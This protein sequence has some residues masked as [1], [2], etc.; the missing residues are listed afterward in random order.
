MSAESLK[1]LNFQSSARACEREDIEMD[2]GSTTEI[3]WNHKENPLFLKRESR[4]RLLIHGEH[5]TLS[6]LC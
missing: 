6:G 2:S 1:Y 5:D 3:Y 4:R